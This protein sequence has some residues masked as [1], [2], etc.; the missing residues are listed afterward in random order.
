[1]SRGYPESQRVT[2]GYKGL[3]RLQMVKW[4]CKGLKAAD[5]GLQ[6]VT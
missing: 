2:G 4:G 5:H 3:E 6:G 1:M